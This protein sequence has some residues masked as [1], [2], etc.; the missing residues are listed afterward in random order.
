MSALTAGRVTAEWMPNTVVRSYQQAASTQVWE[1]GIVV[2]NSSGYA[3]PGVSGTVATGTNYV[4]VGVAQQSQLSVTGSNPNLEVHVGYFNLKADSAFAL[5]AIG[6][7]CYIV[8]DQTVSVTST[9]R[10]PAG[11]VAA[12]DANGN[13]WV[14][15]GL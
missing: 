6:S 5:T 9:N 14:K 10:S 7:N 13:P 4:V 11:V 2:L 3:I 8:D 1:G 15:I 12:I